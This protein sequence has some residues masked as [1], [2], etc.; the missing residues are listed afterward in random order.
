VS[1]ALE[2]SQYADVTLYI[3]RQNS[4]R[5]DYL[6]NNRVK[7]GE[8]ANTSII[9]MVLKIKQNMGRV[10][11]MVTAMVMVTGL[12]QMDIMMMKSPNHFIKS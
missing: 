7:R 11:V 3:V 9:L 5:N 1:D 2:L 6:L 12:T 4:L 10:T 8:I